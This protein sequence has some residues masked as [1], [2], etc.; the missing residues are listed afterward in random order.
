MN[1]RRLLLGLAI[2]AFSL[3]G[4]G[5][6]APP[7][8]FGLGRNAEGQDCR[9]QARF[10]GP[11]SGRQV[12]LY[13]GAW[14][15]PS[16]RAT[17]LPA[18]R[19]AEALALLQHDCSGAETV[20]SSDQ[21]GEM[22][23]VS[24]GL[25]AATGNVPR[26]GLIAVRGS[27][28]VVGT[29][30]PSDWRA[31]VDA[32]RVLTGAAAPG[33]LS[34]ATD[35]PGLREIQS[36]FP[37]GAP[38]QNAVANYELLR[39]RAYE[40]NTVWN[41][42]GSQQD[43][44]EL[45]RLHRSVAPDDVAGEA[46]ILAELA[47]NLSGEERFDEASET[48]DLAAARAREAGD[49]M[50]LRKL[51]NYRA[52]DLMNQRRFAEAYEAADAA[53]RTAGAAS[54]G[55]NRITA[56]D[57][58]VADRTLHSTSSRALV[59]SM[60][61]TTDADRSAVL[62][63]Q[64]AYIAGV[65]GLALGRTDSDRHFDDALADLAATPA[66]PEWLRAQVRQQLAVSRLSH[67]DSAAALGLAQAGLGD[68]R[69]VAPNTRTEAHLLLTLGAAQRA[70]GQ[71]AAA[72]ATEQQAVAIF[73][74]QRERPGLPADLAADHLE[75]L[76]T[77]WSQARDP[78]IAARYLETLSLVW[79]GAAARS[80]SQL[81]AR[82]ATHEV[83]DQA[84]TFQDAERGYR[85][86]LARRQRLALAQ[87]AEPRL[88]AA[89]DADVRSAGERQAAAE[90]ALRARSPRF[91]ELLSPQV[92]A[93][94]L[95]G[96]LSPGE[97]YLRVVTTNQ[98]SFGALIT[99]T[100]VTPFR[101]GLT[102]AQS[103]ALAQ[104]IR[105]SSRMQGRR[106]NDY[107]L[108]AA[109]ELYTALLGPISEQALGL[110]RL[111]IDVSGALAA[112]P[113]AA[114]LTQAPTD[115]QLQAVSDE[116]NYAG[117][118][119]LSRRLAVAQSVGPAAFVRIRR[120]L[121]AAGAAGPT[122]AAI[123]GNFTPSPDAMAAR[124]AQARN[125]SPHCR[126]EVLRA[127][128]GLQALPDTANE[129]QQVAALFGASAHVSLGA[130]FTDQRFLE[131]TDVGQAGVLLM[132]THGVLGLSSCLAEP[133]LIAS[134]GDGGD[135]L[136]EAS[137]LLDRQLHARLVV[138]SACD[139][140]GGGRADVSRT[141]LSDGG[142]AL[143]GLAR[144]F[145]YAGASSVMATQWRVDSATS[146]TEVMAFFQ[147]ALRQHQ[148]LATALQTAQRQVY[149]QAETGHPFYWAPFTLIGDGSTTLASAS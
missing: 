41:F 2:G 45:L 114:L 76:V 19:R 79:D 126:E 85:A 84:R 57:A 55:A 31:L 53:A 95:Q 130:D 71:G 72:L 89:A 16:G 96:A 97:G 73:A 3:A 81:A 87:N 104:R 21:F 109:F 102:S 7:L 80:A 127:I 142:E 60:G 148:P 30:Y 51:A 48:F 22:R 52:I 63:A 8:D 143:S 138:L 145:L 68:I 37:A 5:A 17:A 32:A 14:E 136:I 110:Q 91:L 61:D 33:A 39:R 131:A 15:R 42:G 9:A 86:A 123:F 25:S 113:F 62:S 67:G 69:A 99:A 105:A 27:Q 119:W 106:L 6:A 4:A 82:L 111:Q 47:L 118:P 116:Q 1:A 43:F 88:I 12:D 129:A 26:Y 65:A 149:E 98:G 135:G 107:D 137:E 108:A 120:S 146:A 40:K 144:G 28:I 93:A 56:G 133:A 23:Q 115:E 124:L 117:L 50:M 94:D 112:V 66:A 64:A 134:L 36:V 18:S 44:A 78:A 83:G 11:E 34:A 75:G 74:A 10:G 13:C 141:G 35:S 140:A 70:S 54:G 101:I 29:A 92:S 100:G 90:Q 20:L 128:S 49:G 24:C 122:T 59:F 103:D 38:G 125:L 132:A 77:A 147:A 46:E 121:A 139:T 58:I